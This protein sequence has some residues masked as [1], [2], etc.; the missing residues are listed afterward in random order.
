MW[1]LSGFS[2]EISPD[3]Q[4]QCALVRKLGMG[5][6]EL[7][8]AWGTN[9]LDL[10]ADQLARAKEILDAHG[11]RVSSIGSP[12]GKIFVDEPFPPDV[13]RTAFERARWQLNGAQ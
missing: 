1:T 12:I 2:D 10:D 7:R 11:L 13:A 4:E 3:L 8:S 6:V 9:V 5:F